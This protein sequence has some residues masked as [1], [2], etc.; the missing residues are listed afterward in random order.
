MP[1]HELM[2]QLYG[3]Y[4]GLSIAITVWVSETLRRSGRIFLL[5]VFPGREVLAD[6]VNRLLVVG[7]YLI[8]LGY[9]ALTLKSAHRVESTVGGVE[10]LASKIGLVLLVLGGMHFFN[11][12]I[13]ALCRRRAT[14]DAAQS[15]WR[16]AAETRRHW[17]A[18][19]TPAS[20]AH[21][22]PVAAS[23]VAVPGDAR[24]GVAA[25]FASRLATPRDDGTPGT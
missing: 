9:V 6:A 17:S 20:V 11:M 10:T 15:E 2:M 22:A 25:E 3:W 14:A 12:A 8:N 1:D 5:D 21:A 24:A 7:F 16:R 18:Q 23:A 19:E 4:A 13:F